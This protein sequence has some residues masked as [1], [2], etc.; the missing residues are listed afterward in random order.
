MKLPDFLEEED[1]GFIRLTGHRIGLHHVARLYNDGHSAEAIAAH[2]P[3]LALSHI[4]K[5]IAFYLENET[6]V[7]AY[8]AAQARETDR[9]MAASPAAPTVVEL[10]QRHR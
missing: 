4:H 5:V 8:L 7:N 10:R 3:T 2:Y 9:Q 1:G 6:E